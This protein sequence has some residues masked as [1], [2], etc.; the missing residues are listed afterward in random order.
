MQINRINR[1]MK[2]IALGVMV[3][4]STFGVSLASVGTVLAAPAAV[5]SNMSGV[6]RAPTA[7]TR[8][9]VK[10]PAPELDSKI[11]AGQ[12]L[13]EDEAALRLYYLGFIT[14]N[15][16][17]IN[18]GIEF[19]LG[20]G[21]NRVEAAVFV[22]R[23]L[24]GESEALENHYAHPFTDVPEWASDYVG[25]LYRAGLLESG[26]K[27]EPAAAESTDHFMSCMLYALGYK[28]SH[29]DFGA[30]Q[31]AECAR[32]I[33]ICVTEED[34]PLT[35]GG[36][37]SA[38]YNTLRTTLKGSLRT[39]SDVLAE[40]GVISYN[41]AVFLIW[42]E[43][44]DEVRDYLDAVGYEEVWV[45]PDGYYTITLAGTDKVLNVAA[46]GM[47]ND[48]EGVGVTLWNGSGD[49]TQTFRVE[50]TERGTY[51]IYSAASRNGYGRV[52]GCSDYENG[53]G[54]FSSTGRNAM[55][56]N[57]IGSAD[58]T[59]TIES[60]YSHRSLSAQNGFANGSAV[61][62]SE[63]ESAS[64]NFEREGVMNASGE[65]LAIFVSES[66]YVTQGAY[67]DYSHMSQNAIDIK[68]M[69]WAVR[70]P[71]NAK[72]VRKDESYTACNAVWIE[73]TSKVRY[74]DG[75]YDYMTLCFLHDN[76]IS[77][78]YVG[79]PLTQ[80]EYFYDAGDYGISSG[81]HVH[82]AV[83][84]GSYDAY[85]MRVGDGTI[86][87]EDALFLPDDTYVYEGYGLDWKW[88]SNAS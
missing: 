40:R 13:S 31:A 18:G 60:A 2:N 41:D 5:D 70:S 8:A 39:F 10:E 22:T 68:P 71:F 64:W 1:V 19:N 26:T 45:V 15:G 48:Y 17:Q 30:S 11:A 43:N 59:W 32:N 42:N 49:I 54:L 25:Y 78:I 67:D 84:R 73:S 46:D 9:A 88:A 16:T 53:M 27:F 80:G 34:E 56:F 61:M 47:N 81:K 77:D 14:G 12:D 52:L 21:L 55:E 66:L 29:G 50:R 63:G 82:V 3:L 57:I 24:G 4:A 51:Y 69:E 75:S 6:S 86:N 44:T 58:G 72:V 85:S 33:G 87:I 79:Q 23:L 37:V 65:E 7:K 83:Y 20:Y 38:M 76:D 28:S 74:A 36:A 35:I 62:L